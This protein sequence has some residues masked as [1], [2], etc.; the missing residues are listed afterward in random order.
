MTAQPLKTLRVEPLSPAHLAWFPQLQTVLLGDWLARIEQR[1]PDLL[2]SRSPRC[3]I[4]LDADGPLAAV[5]VQPINRRGSCWTLHRPQ[6]LIRESVHGLRTVQRTLLQTVLHQGDRQVG[7]W[8]MRCP[9]GDADAIAL[10]RELGFQPLRPFQLWH[11]PATPS[12]PA[13]SL[14]QGLTWQPI[15]RRNAQ[16]L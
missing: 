5:V 1:F 14:P 6:Q 11:P 8:V 15:N 13:Q 7:S 4:A 12:A 3:F 9:A 16:R 10:L 2:P